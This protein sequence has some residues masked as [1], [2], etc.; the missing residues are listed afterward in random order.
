MVTCCNASKP[1]KFKT[2]FQSKIVNGS[3]VKSNVT[4]AHSGIVP[5]KSCLF[6]FLLIRQTVP[7]L[8]TGFGLASVAIYCSVVCGG[9]RILTSAQ[10]ERLK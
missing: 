4:Y 5:T 7:S 1:P 6:A 2:V 8:M 9:E 10:L 3:K